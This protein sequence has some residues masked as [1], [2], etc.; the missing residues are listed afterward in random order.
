MA[1]ISGAAQCSPAWLAH[2]SWL[3]KPLSL[4]ANDPKSTYDQLPHVTWCPTG[5]LTQLPLHAAGIYDEGSGP[6]IYNCVVSSYTPSLSALTRS[7]DAVAKQRHVNPS[8]LVVTQP[9]TPGM[10]PLPGTTVEGERLRQ[11]LS[12]AQIAHSAFNGKQ[13][14]TTAVRAALDDHPWLHLAC[15]GS[16]DITDPMKSAFALYDGPLSLTDLMATTANN[17]ELAF[18]SACQT[19]VGDEKIPEESMHLAAGMLAVGYKGVIATMW[20]IRDDDAPLVVEA[21]YKK[22]LGLRASGTL[23]KG[24]TGAAYALHDATKRLREEVGEKEFARWA[25]FVH[26]GV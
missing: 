26:F 9:N 17:A 1:G 14:S 20:S 8:V 24:E 25:P 13:A 15:H 19:A 10:P 11:V 5:P 22:L 3:E 6:R 2:S 4:G 21:Y 23:G 12:Q 16:Q 7:I 18:L